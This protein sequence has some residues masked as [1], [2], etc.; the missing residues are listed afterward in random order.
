MEFRAITS[1][2]VLKELAGSANSTFPSKVR[3][4][5]FPRGDAVAEF[6]RHRT[7]RAADAHGEIDDDRLL[8]IELPEAELVIEI[9]DDEERV[10][11]RGTCRS[12]P[13]RPSRLKYRNRPGFA[14]LGDLC[15]FDS[16]ALHPCQQASLNLKFA[17]AHRALRLA[18]LE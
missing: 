14:S 16:V 11:V 7:R 17:N 12:S 2:S 9:E 5:W 10:G 8:S 18:S 6:H 3:S 4:R 13:D 1:S 15:G